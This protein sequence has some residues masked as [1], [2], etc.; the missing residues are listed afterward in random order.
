M[1]APEKTNRQKEQRA[2]KVLQ[3]M[4]F[5]QKEVN[6]LGSGDTGLRD[7]NIPIINLRPNPYQPRLIYSQEEMDVLRASIRKYGVLEPIGVVKLPVPEGLVTHEIVF[8]E[9][10]FRAAQ[11]EELDI[12][13]ARILTGIS[14]TDM[15]VYPLVE[16]TLREGLSPIET[17]VAIGKLR[18]KFPEMRSEDIAE[19]LCVSARSIQ[20]HTSIFKALSVSEDIRALFEGQSTDVTFRAAYAFSKLGHLI[21]DHKDRFIQI[22][23]AEGIKTALAYLKEMTSSGGEKNETSYRETKTHFIMEIRIPKDA[24]LTPESETAIRQL[25]TLFFKTCKPV[26]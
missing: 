9:R 13:P 8:G 6:A 12:I 26:Q 15:I 1:E 20:Q 22:A 4:G 7:V 17:S 5:S 23:K 2:L 16:N 3:K 19:R 24:E 14:T 11:L 25:L 18:E 21:L 10:R